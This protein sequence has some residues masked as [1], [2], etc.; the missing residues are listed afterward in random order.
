MKVYNWINFECRWDTPSMIII[1]GKC[2]FLTFKYIERV[3][4]GRPLDVSVLKLGQ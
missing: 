3:P 1:G 2:L 4:M